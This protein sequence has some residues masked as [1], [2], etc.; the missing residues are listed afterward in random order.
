M[1]VYLST[2]TLLSSPFCHLVQIVIWSCW[3]ALD[4][5]PWV[6]S[7]PSILIYRLPAPHTKQKVRANSIPWYFWAD[8]SI[9]GFYWMQYT[10]RCSYRSCPRCFKRPTSQV[11]Y[12]LSH[13]LLLTT[14]VFSSESHIASVSPFHFSTPCAS[15]NLS[16]WLLTISQVFPCHLLFLPHSILITA[17]EK[18]SP[19]ICKE[20]WEVIFCKT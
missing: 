13:N 9:C 3:Q 8:L 6:Y 4:S 7:R 10:S 19:P 15:P 14:Q 5:L 1:A 17:S 16:S 2:T 11:E 12:R 18:H 20:M